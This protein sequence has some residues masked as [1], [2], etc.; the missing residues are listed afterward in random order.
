MRTL[1][2]ERTLAFA[3]RWPP[4]LRPKAVSDVI[5]DD[6]E[7]PT[8]G[9]K[10]TVQSGT[11]QPVNLLETGNVSRYDLTTRPGWLLMQ[12]GSNG[13]QGVSIY[14]DYTLADGESVVVAVA[15]AATWE[16]N[17][18]NWNNN[19]VRSAIGLTSGGTNPVGTEPYAW[20]GLE[21]DSGTAYDD[22]VV[23]Y[24]TDDGSGF[25]VVGAFPYAQGALVYLRIARAGTTYSAFVSADGATWLPLGSR[26]S[27]QSAPT[28]LWLFSL[29]AASSA[30]PVPIMA[31]K[32]VRLGSNAFDPWPIIWP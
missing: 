21:A 30:T 7:A 9:A 2:Q 4:I 29:N 18:R 3:D 1:R 16:G 10:W 19:E 31:F 26:T 14:Q 25:Q 27:Y 8:L 22:M 32:F 13:S 17:L 11:S 5:D 28:R 6:F 23:R 12:A 15:M 20:V 24:M